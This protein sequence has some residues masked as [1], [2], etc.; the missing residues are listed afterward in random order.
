MENEMKIEI[1]VTKTGRKAVEK[2]EKKVDNLANEI[3]MLR[4]YIMS[5]DDTQADID[6]LSAELTTSSNELQAAVDQNKGK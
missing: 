6:G 5:Q 3:K 2:L 1:Q 4:H